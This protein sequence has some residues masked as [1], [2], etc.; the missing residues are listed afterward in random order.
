MLF[1]TLPPSPFSSCVI[2]TVKRQLLYSNFFFRCLLEGTMVPGMQRRLIGAE[3]RHMSSYDNA[4]F[5]GK[6][7]YRSAP[8]IAV[9][10]FTLLMSQSS[11]LLRQLKK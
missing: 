5:Q 11:Q 7:C 2:K 4:G 3:D 9:V 8:G 10:S 6:I 1:A